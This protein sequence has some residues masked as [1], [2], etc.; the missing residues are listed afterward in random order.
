MPVAAVVW[1][2]TS[3][4]FA[5]SGLTVTIGE[6]S[7]ARSRAARPGE[8]RPGEARTDAEPRVSEAWVRQQLEPFLGANL[9]RL[10]LAAVA[11]P[12]ERHPWV[13]AVDVSKELPARL[14]VRVAERRAAAVLR[15]GGEL[16]YLD[17]EGRT[18][19][20]ADPGAGDDLAVVS[21]RAPGDADPG[22][23]AAALELLRELEAAD[24][25][26]LADLEEIEILGEGD[27]RVLT[28]G[29]PFP[30][31]VAAGTVEKRV[32]RLEG[33]LPQLEERYGAGAV[34]DLRFERRII[35][36]PSPGGTQQRGDSG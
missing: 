4:R 27:F 17:D 7:E 18:I 2:L 10:E 34:V 21:R 9:L 15:E 24:L 22:A 13:R 8:A 29:L 12:I 1:L 28:A 25:A 30:L 35:V 23:L 14:R 20:P 11:A 16:F 33:L 36:Q 5:L 31:M 26:R 6:P 32:R 19:A 3:E